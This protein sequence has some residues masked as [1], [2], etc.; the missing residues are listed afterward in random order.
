MAGVMLGSLHK[1]LNGLEASGHTESLA[2]AWGYFA[3]A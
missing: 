2:L 1:T 3:G